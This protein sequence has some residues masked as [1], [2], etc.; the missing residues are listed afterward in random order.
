[1][2]GCSTWVG[3]AR[4]VNAVLTL[5]LGVLKWSPS[6]AP[7]ETCGWGTAEIWWEK[8][9]GVCHSRVPALSLGSMGI[10]LCVCLTNGSWWICQ[11]GCHCQVARRSCEEVLA[12]TFLPLK[13][14]FWGGEDLIQGAFP[15]D[16]WGSLQ[17]HWVQPR[18][19]SERALSRD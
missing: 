5:L 10:K 17:G 11:A 8:Q 4:P 14:D 13:G 7:K 15:R 19:P 12:G 16:N 18:G 6:W 2:L 9:A 3:K 1:M